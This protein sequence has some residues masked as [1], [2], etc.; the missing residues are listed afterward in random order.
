M[1]NAIG[2]RFGVVRPSLGRGGKQRADNHRDRPD[3][4]PGARI[5]KS[6]ASRLERQAVAPRKWSFAVFHGSFA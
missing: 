5:K 1:Q 2:R 3:S 6:R 4:T